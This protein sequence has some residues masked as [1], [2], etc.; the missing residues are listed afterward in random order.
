MPKAASDR[1]ADANDRPHTRFQRLR[2]GLFATINKIL[3]R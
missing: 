1:L 2:V 3:R